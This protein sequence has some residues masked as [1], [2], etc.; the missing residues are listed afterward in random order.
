MQSLIGAR[1][2]TFNVLPALTA[3]QYAFLKVL[4]HYFGRH[5]H[6][7]TQRELAGIM[8]VKSTN[9]EAYLKPLQAKGYISREPRRRR[10]IRLTS[11]ALEKLL[12]I[13]GG[14]Q[15]AVE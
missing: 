9:V 3:K 14:R 15:S 12:L 2:G 8:G 6:Y 4:I 1:A 5:R 13:N 11:N 10:N 7:P